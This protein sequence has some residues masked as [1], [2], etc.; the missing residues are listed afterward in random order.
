MAKLSAKFKII[1]E[2][3]IACLAGVIFLLV[4]LEISLRIIGVFN[5]RES[6]SH[7]L[8]HRNSNSYIILCLKGF[9]GPL[10]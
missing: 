3:F 8:T 9:L 6:E 4:I 10:A 2:K 1:V 7:S 5:L